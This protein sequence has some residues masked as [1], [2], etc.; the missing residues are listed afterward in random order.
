MSSCRSEPGRGLARIS[1]HLIELTLGAIHHSIGANSMNVTI[2][3][4]FI[5]MAYEL[6]WGR[7]IWQIVSNSTISVVAWSLLSLR[8]KERIER[9]DVGNDEGRRR[10]AAE[11]G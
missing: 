1:W 10:L 9:K 11:G 4:T 5:F 6:C 8:V 7:H 3:S 2:W